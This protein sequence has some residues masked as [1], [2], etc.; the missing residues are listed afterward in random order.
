MG[1]NLSGVLPLPLSKVYHMGDVSDRT[2]G[3]LLT[4]IDRLRK[5]V[6]DLETVIRL[7]EDENAELTKIQAWLQEE[8]HLLVEE[9]QALALVDP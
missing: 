2:K 3:E 8:A 7:L 4:E 9:S 6:T 5:H 1:S